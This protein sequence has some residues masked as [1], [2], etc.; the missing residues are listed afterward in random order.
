MSFGGYQVAMGPTQQN[1]VKKA[2]VPKPDDSPA[3]V[4]WTAEH[5]RVAV[6]RNVNVSGKLIFN[7]PVRIEG[8][9]RGEVRSD[10]LVVI[11]E[12]G[13]V[14]GKVT[15]P[16]LVVLGEMR[17]DIEGSERVMLGPHSKA[18]GNIDTRKLTICEGAWMDGHVRMAGAEAPK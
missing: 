9:F 4:D 5:A 1:G 15:A 18:I 7:E 2:A 8:R 14:E 12:T 10:S 3:P 13:M 11:A 16:R 17:G 6:G